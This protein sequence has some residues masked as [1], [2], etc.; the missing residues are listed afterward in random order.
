[1]KKLASFILKVSKYV[2]LYIALI[3][4]CIFIK[5]V[6]INERSVRGAY[7]SFSCRV[8]IIAEASP[9]YFNVHNV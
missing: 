1:M 7:E 4:I 9:Y 8:S 5:V 3:S 6:L 2:E